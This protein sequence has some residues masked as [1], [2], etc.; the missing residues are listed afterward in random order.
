MDKEMEKEM[1]IMIMEHYYLKE[2][3][4]MEKEMEKEKNIIMMVNQN[5]KENI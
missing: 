3:I 5:L 1:N 2:N 4:Q